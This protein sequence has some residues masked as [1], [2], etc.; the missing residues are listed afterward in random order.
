[1]VTKG[2]SL[3]LKDA[4]FDTAG[5]YKCVVTVPEIEG[6]QASEVL[7]VKV[8]GKSDYRYRILHFFLINNQSLRNI[9][10]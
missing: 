8:Q 1:M 2:H 9:I 4:T 3:M 5:T 10:T 6:M 7:H